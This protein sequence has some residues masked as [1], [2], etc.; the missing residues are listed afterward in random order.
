MDFAV[1]IRFN[2]EV[3]QLQKKNKT[4]HLTLQIHLK[5]YENI[6]ILHIFLHLRYFEAQEVSQTLKGAQ[7]SECKYSFTEKHPL[8]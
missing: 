8:N 6:F 4:F 3:I 2:F 7:N 1:D 5:E